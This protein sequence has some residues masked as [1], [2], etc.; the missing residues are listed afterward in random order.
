MS[1]YDYTYP[2][3]QI[4][5]AS[6]FST[7]LVWVI[8]SV[9]VAIVGGVALY[10]TFLNKNNENKFKGFL[11]NLYNYLNFKVFIVDH[12][13]RILY[14]INAIL[15]TLISFVFIKQSFLAFI[16]IL[17]VGNIVLRIMYELGLLIFE[18]FKNL[19]EINGKLKK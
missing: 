3:T 8:I 11:A 12:L 18:L 17:I 4:N 1:Y 10:F 13:F 19:K 6:V 15:L 7:S 5:N 2:N 16:L 9:V 14:I